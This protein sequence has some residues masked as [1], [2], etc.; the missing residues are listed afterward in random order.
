MAFGLE[1]GDLVHLARL[2]L[3]QLRRGGRV[4]GDRP[5]C[6]RVKST[7]VDRQFLVDE[8]PDVIVTDKIQ[9]VG[10]ASL[11]LEPVTDLAGEA[12]VVLALPAVL[13]DVIGQRGS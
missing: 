8:H 9:L 13:V 2:Q 10:A 5:R 12:E 4:E 11:V 6:R 7:Q 1:Y 3:A